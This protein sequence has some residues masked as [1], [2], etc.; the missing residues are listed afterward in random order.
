[1]RPLDVL[2]EQTH[3]AAKAGADCQG[4]DEDAGGQLDAKRDDGEEALE[5]HGKE[6]REDERLD[7]RGLRD[8]E[9]L[10]RLVLVA[11]AEEIGDELDAAHARVAVE[12]GQGGGGDG[13]EDDLEDGVARH[14]RLC[15]HV[16]GPKH[17]E[18]GEVGAVEAAKDAD[19][20]KEEHLVK[21]PVLVV[22]HLEE[23][24]LARAKGVDGAERGS[25]DHGTEE[26]AE[27]DLA[28]KVVADLLERE[29]DAADGRT[30]GDGYAGG[31][32]AGEHLATLALVVLV[33]GEDATDDVA[34]A[35][36]NVDKGTLLA[37]REARGDGQ[38]EADGLCEERPEAEIAVDD[39]AAQ[40]AFDLGDTGAGGKVE[41]LAW[42]DGF[43]S[44]LLVG[45]TGKVTGVQTI[46]TVGAGGGVWEE[47]GSLGGLLVRAVAVLT[48]VTVGRRRRFLVEVGGGRRLAGGVLEVEFAGC[49]VDGE[50][51]GDGGPE[52]GD[53][54][55]HRVA[56]GPV[57][58]VGGA[59]FLTPGDPAGAIFG[60]GVDGREHG[61]ER[62]VGV[63]RWERRLSVPGGAT[64]DWGGPAGKDAVSDADAGYERLERIRRRGGDGGVGKEACAVGPGS[65]SG[66]GSHVGMVPVGRVAVG[67]AE[68]FCEPPIFGA[69]AVLEIEED[70]F[71]FDDAA[72][73]ESGDDAGDGDD[74]PPLE[75]IPA[76]D[77]ETADAAEVA[78]AT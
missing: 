36:G 53:D 73:D 60:F 22:R 75:T 47:G 7:L 40:D 9:A 77:C 70:G 39:K 76:V 16:F 64:G 78:D 58:R 6:D 72:G 25:G 74:Y 2:D 19:E 3:D 29:E 59:E 37:E 68:A 52:D 62:G 42:E 55:V 57:V 18:L 65:G 5:D 43:G 34:D 35:R 51:A 66:S 31:T 28:G 27:H 44:A 71:G 46:G 50:D 8:A 15:A 61:G 1:M 41:H 38:G 32:G 23:H 49:E 20:H 21:V 69:V 63:L 56:G 11:L 24:D 4:G 12:E 26:G 30:K 67:A 17:V 14:P 45:A 10:E 54:K 13:D 48:G 33:L